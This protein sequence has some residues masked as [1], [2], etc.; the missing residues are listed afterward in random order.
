MAY[1]GGHDINIVDLPPAHPQKNETKQISQNNYFPLYQE[2]ISMKNWGSARQHCV[3]AVKQN[4]M[5]TG[6]ILL[7]CLNKRDPL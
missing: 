5:T 1:T 6:I 7:P 3:V 4:V 2:I